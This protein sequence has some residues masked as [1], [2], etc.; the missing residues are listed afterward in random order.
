MPNKHLKKKNAICKISAKKV[1]RFVDASDYVTRACLT[2]RA[3][4]SI[5]FLD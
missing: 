4:D 5:N 1:A 2:T 3:F